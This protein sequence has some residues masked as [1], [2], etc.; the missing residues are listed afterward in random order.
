MDNTLTFP[1]TKPQTLGILGAGVWGRTLGQL[2][3]QNGHPVE[4]WSRSGDRS[5]EEI[6]TGADILLSAVSMKGVASVLSQVRAIGVGADTI[7]V[8]A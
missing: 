8:S 7:I 5:L 2:V 6:V 4:Y 3:S 1:P